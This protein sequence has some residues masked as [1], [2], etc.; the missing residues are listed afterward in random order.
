MQKYKRVIRNGL[1]TLLVL[2]G[3][4]GLDAWLKQVNFRYAVCRG[5]SMAGKTWRRINLTDYD[6]K[7]MDLNKARFFECDLMRANFSHVNLS[8]SRL[9]YSDL[10]QATLEYANLKHS[11]LSR[12]V[13]VRANLRNADLTSAIL[14]QTVLADSDLTDAILIDSTLTDCRYTRGTKW[15]RNFRPALHGAKL[16]NISWPSNTTPRHWDLFGP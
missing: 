16:M 5:D 15:P 10:S 14:K 3:L 2:A 6:F 4:W 7:N 9:E 13:I 12:S 1:L 11:D 8:Y